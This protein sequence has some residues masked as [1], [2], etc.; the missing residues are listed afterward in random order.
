MSSKEKSIHVIKFFGNKFDWDGQSE[1]FLAK[2]AFQGYQKL[3]LGK[4][5]KAGYDEMSTARQI[6]ATELKNKPD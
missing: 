5:S 3:L 6:K 4:K 2:A 1:K